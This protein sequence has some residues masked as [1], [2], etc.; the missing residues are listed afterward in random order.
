MQTSHQLQ[1]LGC[2]EEETDCPDILL[3]PVWQLDKSC[4]KEL[5]CPDVNTMNKQ[6]NTGRHSYTKPIYINI[7][8]IISLCKFIIFIEA[9]IDCGK[10]KAPDRLIEQLS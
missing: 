7:I 10:M 5:D 3:S 1:K 6:I 8:F 9:I 4:E 2:F